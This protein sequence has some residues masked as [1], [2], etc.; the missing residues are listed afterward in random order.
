MTMRSLAVIGLC[1]VGVP[2]ST[3]FVSQSNSLAQTSTPGSS[4]LPGRVHP[5]FVNAPSTSRPG[6]T[7]DRSQSSTELNMFMGSDGGVLGIGTPELV[8]S[9]GVFACEV[10]RNVIPAL[11]HIRNIF[12][13]YPLTLSGIFTAS[14]L[15]VY[16]FVGGLFCLGSIRFVQIGQGDWKVCT[17]LSNLYHRGH[18]DSGKQFGVPIAIGRNSKGPTRTQ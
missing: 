5:A 2:L 6:F 1:L 14:L 16:N 4:G 3:A 9:R 10:R 17:E 15:L 12:C 7:S 11:I 18:I 13:M 8:G